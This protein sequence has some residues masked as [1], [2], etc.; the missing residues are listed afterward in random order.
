M[1]AVFNWFTKITGYLPQKACFKTKIYYENKSV[2]SRKIK[3]AAIVASNH[4]SV[5]DFAA[6]MFVF[7]GRTLRCQMAEVLFEKR[8]LGGFLKMLGGIRV[9]RNSHDFSFL[10]ESENILLKGGVVEVYP[11]SRLPLKNEETPLPFKPSVVALA[12]SSGA[13][14]I[15]VY[16]DGA[17]FKKQRAK[18]IIGEPFIAKNYINETKSYKEN[19]ENV[20]ELLRKKIIFLRELMNEKSEKQLRKE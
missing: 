17:Y 7:F 8:M 3:G 15:P 19:V 4:T 16:T 20:T 10:N 13:P 5:Y 18:V 11:E 1:A 12:L 9:D 2:Q 6:L 14:I